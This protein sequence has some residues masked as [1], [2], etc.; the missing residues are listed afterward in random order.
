MSA[1]I[2]LGSLCGNGISTVINSV[3]STNLCFAYF[4]WSV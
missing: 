3:L 1:T 4:V 2:S